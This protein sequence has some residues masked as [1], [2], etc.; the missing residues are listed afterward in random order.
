MSFEK[1]SDIVRNRD[2]DFAACN[3]VLELSTLP[4]GP[5]RISVVT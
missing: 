5:I 1:S 3:T 2:G 4:R